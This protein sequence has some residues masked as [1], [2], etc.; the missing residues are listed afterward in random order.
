MFRIHFPK[1]TVII[2]GCPE[3]GIQAIDF[4]RKHGLPEAPTNVFNLP[5]DTIDESL[6]RQFEEYADKDGDL[7]DEFSRYG[8]VPCSEAT[9]AYSRSQHGYAVE[10]IVSAE[11]IRLRLHTGELATL[12]AELASD[13]QG[14]VVRE[15]AAV[16][17]AAQKERRDAAVAKFLD[18]PIED[19]YK[20][21]LCY[22]GNDN[23][24]RRWS[25]NTNTNDSELLGC[26]SRGSFNW[27]WPCFT[28]RPELQPLVDQIAAECARRNADELEVYAN[29]QAAKKQ[30][31]L[32][33]TAEHGSDRLRACVAEGIECEAI[34]MDERLEHDFPES[35]PLGKVIFDRHDLPQWSDPRNPPM[36]A[37]ELLATAKATVADLGYDCELQYY[38]DDNDDSGYVVTIDVPYNARFAAIAGYSE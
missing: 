36:H 4:R 18:M 35:G 2:E 7:K 28:C 24:G 20:A 32:D 3:S 1:L 5:I 30:E 29:L 15:N 31:R 23:A 9:L 25:L 33:W 37:L 6:V 22:S 13:K 17:A 27:R 10:H 11:A 8:N 21:T 12:I 34:Y 19:L 14:Q 26:S 16:E 38:V